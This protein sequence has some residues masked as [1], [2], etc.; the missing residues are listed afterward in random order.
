M[1]LPEDGGWLPK[2]GSR[3]Y[4][5]IVYVLYMH[6]V[7][8]MVAITKRSLILSEDIQKSLAVAVYEMQE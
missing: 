3:G 1:W 5:I 7:G 2:M 6:T 4:C 8:F